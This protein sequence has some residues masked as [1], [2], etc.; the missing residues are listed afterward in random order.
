MTATA[1]QPKSFVSPLFGAS[2][3]LL[4]SLCLACSGGGEATD[5]AATSEAPA[6][7]TSAAT[8]GTEAAPSATTPQSVFG[9]TLVVDGESVSE[10]ELRR[11]FVM[12]S[13]GQALLESHK[14]QV[15][16]DDE[17]DARIAAGAKAEDFYVKDEEIE[18]AIAEAN[19]QLKKEFPDGEY[20][21]VD[22]LSHYRKDVM[23]DQI[24]QTQLFDRV[25]LP[26]NPNEYPQ[27]TQDALAK[28]G[29][30]T[31]FVEKLKEGYEIRQ[32]QPQ[33]QQPDPQQRALFNTILRQMVMRHLFTTADIQEVQDG[34]PV[35]VAMRVNGKDIKVAD[36]WSLIEENVSADDVTEA[37]LWFAKTKAMR[38]ALRKSGHYIEDE[39]FAKVYEEHV[40]PYEDSPF[41]IP[42]I[43]IGFKKF[44][45]MSAYVTYY[46]LSESYKRSIA[47]E[48]NDEALTA[49]LARANQL[50]GLAKVNCEV[51]LCSAYDFKNRK[52]KENGWEQAADKAKEVVRQLV[53][54]QRPWAETLEEHSEWWDQPLGKSQMGIAVQNSLNK[55]R[56]GEKNRN[57]LLQKMSESD[58]GLFVFGRSVTDSIFFDMEPGTIDGP[59]KGPRGYYIANLISR[60]APSKPIDIGIEGQ[61]SLVE[62]DYLTVRLNA[63]AE[64]ALAA[65]DVQGLATQGSNL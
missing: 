23:R 56:F 63:F 40:G 20:E 27:I 25:F 19:A 29:Q 52:W 51:I 12:G 49:H 50:L 8:A 62:Q 48:I 46:R 22:E 30:G 11:F 7:A 36:I 9:E 17:I 55:G 38:N 1:R 42:V 16:I 39:E 28:G 43:A 65:A 32:Q 59:F 37:K 24:E 44:P 64:E 34:L 2:S 35:D 31:D 6:D 45:S 57:E 58:Y 10:D 15:L 21:T 54:D 18:A 14:L 41:S 3:A 61:R 33:E 5:P 4:A 47:D 60:S 26:E 53:E 13:W